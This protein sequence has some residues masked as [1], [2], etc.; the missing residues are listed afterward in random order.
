M[1]T[2]LVERLLGEVDHGLFADREQPWPERVE[3]LALELRSRLA[4]HP[5][6]V[7]L[8]IGG[9]M[10]GPQALALNERLLELLADAGQRPA[11]GV[12]GGGGGTGRPLPMHM[13]PSVPAWRTCSAPPAY[14]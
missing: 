9:P 7:P 11:G 5:A 12:G 2:A 10:D 14:R 3:S 1:F 8:M 6:V 13:I 4:A